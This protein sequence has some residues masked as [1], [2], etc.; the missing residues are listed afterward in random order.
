MR[1]KV[2]LPRLPRVSWRVLAWAGAAI[3]VM[4]TWMTAPL[5]LRRV[6]PS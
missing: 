3:L 2:R 5:A 6:H 1:L 4:V